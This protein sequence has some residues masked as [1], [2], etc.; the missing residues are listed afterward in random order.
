VQAEI[1]Q[2]DAIREKARKL[3]ESGTSEPDKG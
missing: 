3:T 2:T 1:K